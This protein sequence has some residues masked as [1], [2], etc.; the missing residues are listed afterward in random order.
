MK[1]KKKDEEVYTPPKQY[2]N[3]DGTTD[4]TMM[5]RTFSWEANKPTKCE[6]CGNKTDELY[7]TP[8]GLCNWRCRDCQISLVESI[9][10]EECFEHQENLYS[11]PIIPEGYISPNYKP[12][13]E[14]FW[15]K[16]W[17]WRKFT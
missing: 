3:P 6:K 11:Y 10:F 16:I 17:N 1:F 8:I 2:F 12:K 9:G 14:S 13:K 15:E 7:C 5:P 4:G